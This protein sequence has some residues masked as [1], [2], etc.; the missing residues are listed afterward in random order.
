[1]FAFVFERAI[2]KYM[3]VKFEKTT[4]EVLIT[5][6]I[7]NNNP[8]SF[9][10]ALNKLVCLTIEVNTYIKG[11]QSIIEITK[12]NEITALSHVGNIDK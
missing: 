1:M 7:Q 3:Y 10:L 2:K 6:K 11:M 9:F 5:V 12:N 8:L 4:S